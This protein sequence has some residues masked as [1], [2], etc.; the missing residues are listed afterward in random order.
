MYN[1]VHNLDVPIEFKTL[2]CFPNRSRGFFGDSQAFLEVP[3]SF[4]KNRKQHIIR[5]F[6]CIPVGFKNSNNQKREANSQGIP[7]VHRGSQGGKRQE[8][9]RFLRCSQRFWSREFNELSEV[10]R[11]FQE[12]Q[13]SYQRFLN[14]SQKIMRNHLQRQVTF[15]CGTLRCRNRIDR[16][17]KERVNTRYL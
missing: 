5:G 11:D 2:H 16:N 7:G 17:K 9:P 1:N 12:L 4:I 6:Q 3:N 10:L 15:F 13:I 8:L 14:S